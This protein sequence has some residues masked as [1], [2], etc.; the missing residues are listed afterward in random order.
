MSSLDAGLEDADD[1]VKASGKQ[2]QTPTVTLANPS[3]R[4]TTAGVKNL[5][6]LAPFAT[7]G[8]SLRHFSRARCT[9]FTVNCFGT[10]DP[11]AA[12]CGAT[13]FSRLSPT[14]TQPGWFGWNDSISARTLRG[15]GT[16][17]STPFIGSNAG[18]YTLILHLDEMRPLSRAFPA[19][20]TPTPPVGVRRKN[21]G[22]FAPSP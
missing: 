9:R 22:Q 12:L 15:T 16:R 18:P 13:D 19:L 20:G 3:I 8:G 10:T 4:G 17:A 2:T 1:M 11:T 21:A 7:V 5:T 6:S 14:D